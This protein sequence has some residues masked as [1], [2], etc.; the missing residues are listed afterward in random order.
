MV[1]LGGG[2]SGYFKLCISLYVI[3]ILLNVYACDIDMQK[4]YDLL[5][6]FACQYKRPFTTVEVA[7]CRGE[8]SLYVAKKYKKA[9]CV[10]IEGNEYRRMALAD[11][12]FARCKKAKVP[13]IILLGE[14]VHV[15]NIQRLGECEHFDLVFSF[16]A[17]ERVAVE[18]KKLID[19]MLTLGDHLMLE[20]P[21]N[22]EEAQQ[23][24]MAKGA[25]LLATLSASMVYYIPCHKNTLKRK[26]WMRPLESS[27]TIYSTFEEKK[28]VKIT[29]YNSNKITSD[30]KAGINLITFKMYRGIYPDVAQV[31]K[32]LADIEYVWHNDWA[33]HNIIIQGDVLTLIDYGDPRMNGHY[34]ARSSAR[35][36]LYKKILYCLEIREPKD[37]ESYFWRY[38]KTKPNV[39]HFRNF[40]KKMLR[41]SS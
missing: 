22:Q 23:Y 13:N 7:A 6:I 26:T 30:W 17:I 32:A 10:M 5:S 11:L 37:V 31:K 36:Q 40:I 14:L 35:E 34:Q 8:G 28:L 3:Q 38:L 27:I 2:M 21:D 1:R 16:N 19:A 12:L 20:I 29:P 25:S 18:W 41:R 39:H 4:R 33:M 9:V 15:E 24:F